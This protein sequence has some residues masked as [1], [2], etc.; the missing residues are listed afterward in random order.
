MAIVHQLPVYACK[1]TVDRFCRK[2]PL[3]VL[4]AVQIPRHGRIG[5]HACHGRHKERRKN[6]ASSSLSK[7]GFQNQPVTTATTA[8]TM[9]TGTGDCHDCHGCHGRKR[10]SGI[11]TSG[12]VPRPPYPLFLNHAIAIAAEIR[13]SGSF[14]F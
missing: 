7:V 14:P 6:Y 11:W 4:E 3:V 2:L 9:T 1:A 12:S 5:R 13:E 8:T 10:E